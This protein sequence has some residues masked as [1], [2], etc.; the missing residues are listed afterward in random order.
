MAFVSK[1]WEIKSKIDKKKEN[2]T[3]DII[4]VLL[5]NRKIGTLD[6]EKEFFNPPHPGLV[7]LKDLEISE[8]E[9]EKAIAR[10]KVAI[11]KKEK[12]FVYGDYDCDGICATAVLWETL[13]KLG[14]NVLP[15]I[16]ERVKEGYGLNVETLKKLKKENS[17]LGLIFT[18]DHGIVSEKKVDIAQELGIDVVVTDHHEPGKIKPAALAIIHTTKVCGAAVSWFLARE[19]RKH[20]KL[21]NNLDEGL[22][23]VAIGTIADQMPLLEINRSIAKHGLEALNKTERVGLNELF[24]ES[25]LTKGRIGTYA[26]GFIIAPRLNSMGRLTNAI[27]SLRLLC[28]KNEGRAKEIA[29]TIGSTNK[30]RQSIVDEVILHARS[31]VLTQAGESIIVIADESYHEGVIGLAAAKIVEEFWRPAI[32]LS[33]KGDL[34]KASARSIPGFNIIEA[35]RNVEELL[36]EGGGHPM[37]A[38]FSIKVEHIDLF[39]KKIREV[40]TPLLTEEVLSKKLTIDMELAFSEINDDLLKYLLKFEPFGLGNPE[41]VFMTKSLTPLYLRA[42]GSDGRHIKFKV[43]SS[44]GTQFSA[45]GFSMSDILPDLEKS[46]SIDLAYSLQENTWNGSSSIELKV[47]DVKIKND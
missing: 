20:F 9:I 16:P 8:K 17:D 46:K 45:I 26:V 35:I 33:K 47:K 43:S 23:L 25:G 21:D 6:K 27:D 40:S 36:I 38:G 41:P 44:E 29:A 13:F 42:I 19:I 1:R 22:D 11:E 7:S 15:Y 30:K 34:A 18:V 14:A 10:L 28:T 3:E 5:K 39:I 24:T 4:K 31:T 37:A 2:S 12:I 32:V